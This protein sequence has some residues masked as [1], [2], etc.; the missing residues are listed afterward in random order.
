[1]QSTI[2]SKAFGETAITFKL[3]SFNNESLSL[4]AF[5]EV[6]GKR[7]GGNVKKENGNAAFFPYEK[8]WGYDNFGKDYPKFKA[9]AKEGS[10]CIPLKQ[11]DFDKIIGMIN[12]AYDFGKMK[13]GGYEG[14]VN[15]LW[16]WNNISESYV[17]ATEIE[18]VKQAIPF[19]I[20]KLICRIFER[21]NGLNSK[22]QIDMIGETCINDIHFDLAALVEVA[23]TFFQKELSTKEHEN[24]CIE[25]AKTTGK[26]VLVYSQESFSEKEGCTCTINYIANPNGTITKEISLHE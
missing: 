2:T 25:K 13:I 20:E 17:S 11:G 22:F 5:M 8:M 1:M 14:R 15:G 24:A 9:G 6:K 21:P 23:P 16:I 10:I 18:A 7:Y 12:N 26:A 3:D 19:N 4:L